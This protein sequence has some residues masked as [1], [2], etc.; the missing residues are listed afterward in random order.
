MTSPNPSCRRGTKPPAGRKTASPQEHHNKS[1]PSPQ[2]CH[3]K[4]I[5]LL[6]ERHN[7]LI[8]LLQECHNKLIPLLQEG[9]GEVMNE[10]KGKSYSC[11]PFR[12]YFYVI[13]TPSILPV[14]IVT[15]GQCIFSR[16]IY[17]Y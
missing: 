16:R 3:N 12:V 7:K 11:E 15:N 17:S 1:S 5:P 14:T 6:Q 10:G 9:L 4:L 2:G 8:P 13:T